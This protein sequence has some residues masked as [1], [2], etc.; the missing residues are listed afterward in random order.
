MRDKKFLYDLRLNRSMFNTYLSNCTFT[1]TVW[2][3]SWSFM[4]S[5]E[6][7]N[8]VI[9][10]SSNEH[11]PAFH[12]REMRIIY[13]VFTV[14]VIWGWTEH[15]SS[16]PKVFAVGLACMAVARLPR[17]WKNTHRQ[18]WLSISDSFQQWCIKQ[19]R[20]LTSWWD[21]WGSTWSCLPEC[22]CS[23]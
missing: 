6:H 5:L 18:K 8:Y 10:H 17:S 3:N 7:R 4:S 9:H 14:T 13:C 1:R 23:G 11:Y 15:P 22:F 16:T 20:F 21:F 12:S 2:L 19:S